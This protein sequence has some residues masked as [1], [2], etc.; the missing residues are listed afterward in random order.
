MLAKSKATNFEKASRAPENSCVLQANNLIAA[1]YDVTVW[2]RNK[3]K[4]LPLQEKG[5]KVG[6]SVQRDVSVSV[7]CMPPGSTSCIVVSGT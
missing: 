3:D 5:A 6:F 7:G 2:N 4:C 1:G